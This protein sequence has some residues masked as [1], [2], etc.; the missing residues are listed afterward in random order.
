MGGGWSARRRRGRKRYLL[1]AAPRARTHLERRLAVQVLRHGGRLQAAAQQ[2]GRR[3]RRLHGGG[4][5]VAGGRASRRR[6]GTRVGAVATI[7]DLQVQG[8]ASSQPC[9]ACLQRS[10]CTA[11]HRQTARL[12]HNSQQ[13]AGGAGEHSCPLDWPLHGKPSTM[14]PG[15]WRGCLCAE[16]SRTSLRVPP[17][18]KTAHER[19]TFCTT[20][21]ESDACCGPS[22]GTSAL[23]HPPAGA[24]VAGRQPASSGGEVGAGSAGSPSPS[25]LRRS[26]AAAGTARHEGG[27]PA[28]R[29]GGWRAAARPAVA[30]LCCGSRR[31]P[32][33][34]PSS[35]QATTAATFRTS[36]CR[37]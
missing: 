13:G 30:H 29:A 2:R 34:F 28:S 18:S 6:A 23:P 26:A 16:T 21:L 20:A 24:A 15:C 1:Q 4:A 14:L 8:L 3:L 33:A 32:S 37:V 5:G 7:G 25:L 27:R 35:P 19:R 22:A 31:N 17:N 9:S 36:C 11:V 12:R 10:C